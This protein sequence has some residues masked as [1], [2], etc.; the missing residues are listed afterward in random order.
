MS[1][2]FYVIKI[3][4]DHIHLYQYRLDFSIETS[5]SPKHT[6]ARSATTTADMQGISS[7][8]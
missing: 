1:E 8:S 2:V 6:S 5:N 3:G 7:E 4:K